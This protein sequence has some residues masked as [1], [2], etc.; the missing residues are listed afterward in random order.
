MIFYSKIPG[1]VVNSK[2]D[3]KDRKP[4][5]GEKLLSIPLKKGHLHKDFDKKR[6]STIGFSGIE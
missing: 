1:L 6:S 2:K 4:T 3:K 5:K